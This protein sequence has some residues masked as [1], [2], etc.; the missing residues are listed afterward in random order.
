MSFEK[1]IVVQ[2]KKE[3]PPLG[4]RTKAIGA[5]AYMKDVAPF[6]G[7]MTPLR[8]STVRAIV[9]E[10]APPTSDQ[11]GKAARALWKLDHRE[12]QYAAHDIIDFFIDSADK[13]FLEEHVQFLLTTKPW[14]DTVDSLGSVAISPLTEKYPLVSLMKKWNK[15]DDMWLNRAA[16]QHQ[17]GRKEFTDVKFLLQFCHDHAGDHRFFIAK[18]IGWALRDLSRWNK[19]AVMKFLRE[20]PDLDRVAVREATRY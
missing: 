6:L 3:F 9:R 12:Y 10:F 13:G 15:S 16:I 14:W 2:L 4:N 17:R 1:E 19:P 18:A 8:R 5:Q 20:H 11:L 7:I